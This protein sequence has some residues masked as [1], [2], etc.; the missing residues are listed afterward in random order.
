MATRRPTWT[1]AIPGSKGK[2]GHDPLAHRQFRRT[3]IGPPPFG[4]SVPFSVN[5]GGGSIGV[6]SPAGRHR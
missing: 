2:P 1:T 5:V 6:E 3:G 4:G